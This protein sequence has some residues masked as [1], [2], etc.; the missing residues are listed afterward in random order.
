MVVTGLATRGLRVG[1]YELLSRI[2]AGGMGEVFIARRT[3]LAGFEKRVALK[4]LLPHL[5][6]EP[7]LVE[8][9][10]EEARIAARMEHPHI[11]PLFD[12]GEADGRYY[13]AMALVE[14]V[15]LSQ[16]LRACRREGQRLSLP[17]V[18]AVATGLCEALDYAHHLRGPGG[19]D[20]G[21]VHRDVSPSNVMVSTR[22][23]VLL[24]DFGIARVLSHVTTRSR[25]W[26]K[27]AYMPPEQLEATGPVD[28]RADVFAAAVTLYQALT[29]SSP[30]QRE[31]D[32]AT[33]DAIRRESLP[34]VTHLRPDASARLRDTLQQGAARERE[35]R[36]PSARALLDGLLEG[37][38]A[39]PAELGAL[40]E[41]LCAAELALFRQPPPSLDAG[42]TRTVP[43]AGEPDEVERQG[44]TR[45]PRRRRGLVLVGGTAVVV[46]GIGLWWQ[47]SREAAASRT[48][49]ASADGARQPPAAPVL[50]HVSSEK[51]PA[52]EDSARR[53]P[54]S[55]A[56]AHAPSQE[57]PALEDGAG[58]PPAVSVPS[59][60]PMEQP[61][62][63]EAPRHSSAPVRHEPARAM[64]AKA[65]AGIGY[66]TVDA[67]PWA[68][69]S[70]DGREVDRTPLARYPLPAGRHT[71]VFHN[72][73]LG[74]TEQRTVRIEP[75]AVAT[76]RVDFEPTR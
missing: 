17:V 66:L 2:A 29:L 71:I 41:S 70:V 59:K 72:P 53:P 26:G 47:G 16:L 11:I 67:R 56:L 1:P 49:E 36:L 33:M 61:A 62:P 21:V 13:L 3:G 37:P 68:V 75:G 74:R 23:A 76:L 57:A 44:A 54:H 22:G 35:L 27:F 55:P 30:F 43:P 20:F 45:P 38:V 46:A 52:H 10:L 34:D 48:G 39:G 6:E 69:I 12:A 51:A 65:P 24:G 25:P 50:A 63:V 73:V 40:V 15:S 28:A 9:F 5:S 19:E 64:E 7:A 14:G 4:L 31:T 32:P 60:S 58:Q 42:P 8:R 18:R